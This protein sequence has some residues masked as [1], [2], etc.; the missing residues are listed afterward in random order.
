MAKGGEANQTIG[1]SLE[2]W[3]GEGRPSGL[4]QN[5]VQ[6]GRGAGRGEGN[7]PCKRIKMVAAEKVN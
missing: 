6:K 5:W 4:V 2:E 7:M 3:E 1:L